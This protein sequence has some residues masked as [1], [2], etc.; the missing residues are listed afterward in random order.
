LFRSNQKTVATHPSPPPP[1]LH[2]TTYVKFHWK[3]KCG[4]KC[5]LDD[6]AE[7]VGGANHSHATQ[8]LFESIAAGDYPEWTLLIQTMDPATEDAHEFDPLDVTKLWPEDR[9]P[10]QPVGRM[11]LNKNPDNF[12]AENEM[13]A[14]CPALVVPGIGY[15]DDKLLQTRIF[16]YADTQVRERE[17][18]GEGGRGGGGGDLKMNRIDPPPPPPH[19]Q[20]RHRLGPNSLLLP[21]NAPRAPHHNNHH[22]GAMNFMHRDEE[23]NYFPSRL[24][25][26]RHADRTPTNPAVLTGR[27]ERACIPKE[28]NFQQPGERFRSWDGARQDRFIARLCGIVGDARATPEIRRV[29]VGYLTQC[30]A[31]LGKR[32]AAKLQSMGAA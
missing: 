31:G 16:S 29:W 8:D 18:E 15:S 4:V 23:V 12:F 22:D 17:E 7:R 19:F 11:V 5:L 9:F 20:Q 13:L 25:P 1:L 21:A 3:P 32:V 10:L 26:A 30:D 27:R 14:F 6:E 28:N 2:Q 24:A